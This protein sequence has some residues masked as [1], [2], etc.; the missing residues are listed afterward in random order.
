M[1]FWPRIKCVKFN[2]LFFFISEP[3]NF[4]ISLQLAI[5]KNI[6][7]L[8]DNIWWYI[9]KYCVIKQL[10]PKLLARNVSF[11]LFLMELTGRFVRT[12][13]IKDQTATGQTLI[14][15]SQCIMP[16]YLLHTTPSR[17]QSQASQTYQLPQGLLEY[18]W[19]VSSQHL[20][21]TKMF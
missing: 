4:W 9:W 15:K 18:L 1:I 12:P 21:E 10:S 19:L 11:N 8:I 5:F 13:P 2:S 3:V 20:C 14:C 6:A 16:T 7:D 17:W